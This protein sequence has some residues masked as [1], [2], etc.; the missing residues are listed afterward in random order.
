MTTGPLTPAANAYPANIHANDPANPAMIARRITLPG[1][2]SIAAVIAIVYFA[3]DVILPLAIAVLITFALSPLAARLRK[4]GLPNVPAVLCVVTL[5]VAVVSLFFL[6]VAAQLSSLSQNLPTFQANIIAKVE[7]LREAGNGNGLVAQLGRTI[8]AINDEISAATPT[9]TGPS[10]AQTEP[11]PLPVEVVNSQS[12]MALLQDLVIPLISPIATVGLVIVIVI[13]M[14]LQREDLRDRFIRLVGSNDIHRTTYVLKDAGQRVTQYLLIQLLVNIIYAIPIGIGLY[15]IGVPNAVLW[16]M[17]TLVLRFVPYIGSVLAAAFPLFL[18]FAVSPDWSAVLWTLALFGTVELI[19]SNFIEPYLYGSRTGVSPL[20]I[21]VSA[22]FWTWVWG[23][24]GLVLST[25]MTVCLVVL[26][27]HIPQFQVFDIIFGDEPVLAPHARLYQRL[28]VG[29]TLEAT[30]RAEEAVETQYLDEYYRDVGIP[31]LQ[32]AQYDHARGVL[33]LDQRTRVARVAQQ[34]VDDLSEVAHEELNEVREPPTPPSDTAPAPLPGAGFRLLCV[35]GRSDLDDVSAA[36]L[37]QVMA[38]EGADA[39]CLAHTD[40]TAARMRTQL[41]TALDAMVLAF[42]D[43]APARASFLHIRRIKQAAPH[44]RVG[45]VV[46]QQPLPSAEPGTGGAPG[47][48]PGDTAAKEVLQQALDIGADFAVTSIE[49]AL[50]AAFVKDAPK[51]IST[52]KRPRQRNY[53]RVVA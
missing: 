40:L 31:A 8:T 20:A 35:G 15:F 45:V 24:T 4:T 21:I 26:G 2:A 12:P 19:T 16:G 6:V 23:P 39:T 10:A 48:V 17:L 32:I 43:P 1:L 25:P 18:A 37:A 27:R 42:L 13:F 49:A 14:L 51:P 30:A 33:T 5:A 38:T 50:L 46:W 53:M 29:D 36:M 3:K 11:V 34:M 41:P 28:L 47:P 44:L 52:V 7:G 9:A 22:I